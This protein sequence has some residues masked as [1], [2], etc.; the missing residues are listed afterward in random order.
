[1]LYGSLKDLFEV[2]KEC[3]EDPLK[4]SVKG[5]NNA[6][7]DT[8]SFCFVRYRVTTLLVVNL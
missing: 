6:S 2:P 5:L 7:T 4:D 8:A 1:M 3:S